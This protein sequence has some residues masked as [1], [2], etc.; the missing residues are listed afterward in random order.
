MRNPWEPSRAS[1][2][3]RYDGSDREEGGWKRTKNKTK[4]KRQGCSSWGLARSG[5]HRQLMALKKRDS[6]A[7][8]TG[9][10]NSTR[11]PLKPTKVLEKSNQTLCHSRAESSCAKRNLRPET[12]SCF[13]FKYFCDHSEIITKLGNSNWM[14]LIKSIW[15]ERIRW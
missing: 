10:K 7:I 11:A 8:R 4:E 14:P 9:K 3:H 6:I 15:Y 13:F 2:S 12:F 5:D 1:F